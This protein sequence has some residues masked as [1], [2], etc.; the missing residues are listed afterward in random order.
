MA[1]SNKSLLATEL[2]NIRTLTG[3]S[4]LSRFLEICSSKRPG[5][6][7]LAKLDT[8]EQDTVYKCCLL[9]STVTEGKKIPREFQLNAVLALL[10]GKDCLIDAGTGSGK[11]LCM[12]LPALLDPAA[13]SLV[14]SPL[15]RLQIL[16]VNCPSKVMAYF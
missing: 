16:Q 11:T 13:I 2:K 9:L 15:K 8:T 14:I 3:D 6:D 5:H 4:L 10:A 12:I 1:D 7:F